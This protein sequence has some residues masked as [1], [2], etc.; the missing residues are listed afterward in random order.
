M[1]ASDLLKNSVRTGNKYAFNPGRHPIWK[2][3]LYGGSTISNDAA[4]RTEGVE[5]TGVVAKRLLCCNKRLHRTCLLASVY[6][7]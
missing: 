5:D 3:R 4:F 7:S 1:G 2:Y 6:G